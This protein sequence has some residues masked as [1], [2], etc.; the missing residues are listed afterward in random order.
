MKIILTTH[1]F[2]P[3]FFSG[4]EILAFET[5]KELQRLGHDI[6]VFTGFPA[7]RDVMDCDRFDCYCH[8]GVPVTRFQHGN[9]PMGKQ[10][11]IV[12]AEYNNLFFAAYFRNYLIEFQP[13]LVHFFHLQRLSASAIDV[14]HELNIP[15]VMTPTDF[16]L[17]CPMN[18]LRLPDNSLCT[19]PDAGS[20]NCLK[21][22]VALTQTGIA[23]TFIGK[24]PLPILA[25]VVGAVSWKA[26]PNCGVFPLVRA[27]LKRP[28][29]MRERINKLAK[30]ILPT[31]LMGKILQEN[32]L[33]EK[34]G[35][36]SP[37]GINLQC[38]ENITKVE[39]TEV[40]RVGFIG[41]LAEHKGAHVLID[42]VRLLSPDLS[43]EVKLYGKLNDFPDYVEKLKNSIGKDKRIKFCGTF[44]NSEIGEIFTH[45]DV[46]V[47]PSI[48][49]ENTPLVI[50]S[51]Q[52]AGCPVI[53][54]N[55]G[56]M[57]EVVQHGDNGLLFQAGD[58]PGLASLIKSIIQEPAML[59]AL[60]EKANMPKSIAEYATELV[61][62]YDEVLEAKV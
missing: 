37:F 34:R 28:N 42:A 55:L 54:S 62:I 61:E 46:L 18:Q 24:C 49:Y 29:F 15:M 30:V 6:S 38:L 7:D 58:S 26:M 13:D 16:W 12:E 17:V 5:A 31:R 14:C 41:T 10:F 25:L 23:A 60:A 33:Q 1:Q 3:E 53:A 2:L 35:I 20:I 32:G 9:V 22:I 43:L 44:P 45:L 48:W 52:A 19:G 57:A 51:A 4:T 39:Q 8:D 56:G 50:Y 59:Q 40:L 11:N 27:L 47:V 36:F 21:H